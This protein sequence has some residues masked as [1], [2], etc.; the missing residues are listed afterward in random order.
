MP[1]F[2]EI[3]SRKILPYNNL[4]AIIF[5]LVVF[6]VAGYYIYANYNYKKYSINEKIFGSDNKTGAKSNQIVESK[7]GSKKMSDQDKI[8]LIVV[9][10]FSGFA[11][12]YGI[13]YLLGS[14][15]VSTA[16]PSVA[17]A[18]SGILKSAKGSSDNTM[19]MY[20]LATGALMFGYVM[21][22]YFYTP[23]YTNPV[24]KGKVAKAGSTITVHFF[25]ADWCPHCRK[26]KPAIDDFEKEYSNKKINGR[27]IIINRVDC[28]DSEVEEVSKQI[29]QFNVTSF[30]TVK[31]SDNSGNVFDFDA[32][33]TYENLKEFV[34]SVATN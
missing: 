4:F 26:A 11:I 8:I 18:S 34:N 20:L 24:K 29:N 21:Y 27:T 23:K 12:I 25:T 22:Y 1:G 30:P 33:L 10:L 3:V 28:T 6:S 2:Y 5:V 31:I 13:Y 9:S 7:P 32:K 14:S 19:A 16:G 17:T 15:S